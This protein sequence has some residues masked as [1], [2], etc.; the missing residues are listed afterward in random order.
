MSKPCLCS[1]SIHICYASLMLS[2]STYALALIRNHFEPS[3]RRGLRRGVKPVIT[4]RLGAVYR[5]GIVVHRNHG[6][7]FTSLSCFKKYSR[8]IVSVTERSHDRTLSETE[9]MKGR[10]HYI[11][12]PSLKRSLLKK[13]T[14]N[15]SLA[16]P[17]TLCYIQSTHHC[18]FSVSSSAIPP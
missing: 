14:A 1:V 15:L 10:K 18:C 13:A 12:G 3:L 17:G 7:C 5:Y 4:T 2:R 16:Y 11:R 8:C 9:F 6:P